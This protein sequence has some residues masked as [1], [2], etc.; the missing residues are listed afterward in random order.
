MNLIDEQY[1]LT[2]YYGVRRMTA[3]LRQMGY[4]ESLNELSSDENNED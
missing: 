2:P 3:V 4:R 1:T